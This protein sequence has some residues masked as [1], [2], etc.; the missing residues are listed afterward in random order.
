VRACC[1]LTIQT[2]HTGLSAGPVDMSALMP[3][4]PRDRKESDEMTRLK[5]EVE[6]L[7]LANTEL[8][9]KL[10]RAQKDA[11]SGNVTHTHRYSSLYGRA[12]RVS[13]VVRRSVSFVYVSIHSIH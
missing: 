11:S 5:K 2:Q 13:L 8:T 12:T 4:S 9:R 6:R 10:E 3:A 1:L 7:Q